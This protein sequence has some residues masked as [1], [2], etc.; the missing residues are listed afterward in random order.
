[1]TLSSLNSLL[2]EQLRVLYAAESQLVRGIPK[3]IEGVSSSELKSLL[4]QHLAETEKHLERLDAA[5]THLHEKLAG[6]RCRPVEALLKEALDLTERRGDDRVLDAG[7][8]AT[9][10]MIESFEKTAYELAR[11][12]VEVLNESE[13]LKI[14]D[15][16]LLDENR[17]EQSMTVL[18]EDLIDS[19]HEGARAHQPRGAMGLEEASGG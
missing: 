1:M 10:R 18:F 7:V 11:D 2:L 5:A 4:A 8:I 19:I 16:N 14:V 13:I 9:M 15:A 12:V 17:C 6:E 3:L